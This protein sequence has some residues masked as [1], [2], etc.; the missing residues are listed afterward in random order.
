MHGLIHLAMAGIIGAVAV[1]AENSTIKCAKGLKMFVSRGTG[2]LTELGETKALV[3]NIAKQIDGSNI[4][5]ILYPASFDDP[6]YMVSV[7]NGTRLVRKAI[8]EYAKACPDSK[9]ALFGYS[10][11]ETMIILIS[12][13]IEC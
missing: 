13:G 6:V 11:V 1:S 9:M 7:S 8:T 5:P 2:E 12:G 10:Q 3:D 4:Q